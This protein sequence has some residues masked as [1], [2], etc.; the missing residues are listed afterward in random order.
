MMINLSLALSPL[1]WSAMQ[2]FPTSYQKCEEGI[3]QLK[4]FNISV[5]VVKKQVSITNQMSIIVVFLTLNFVNIKVISKL[6]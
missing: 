5:L 2:M 6:I 3:K 1:K 4:L